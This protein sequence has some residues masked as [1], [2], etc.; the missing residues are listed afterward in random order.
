MKTKLQQSKNL[1]NGF[2]TRQLSSTNIHFFPLPKVSFVSA[3][4][5]V[6]TIILKRYHCYSRGT[7]GQSVL[8]VQNRGD[9]LTLNMSSTHW[10]SFVLV[11]RKERNNYESQ[12]ERQTCENHNLRNNNWEVVLARLKCCPVD[13]CG[14]LPQYKAK[15]HHENLLQ[16]NNANHFTTLSPGIPGFWHSCKYLL[17][18]MIKDTPLMALAHPVDIC[19]P[20]GQHV[21]SH[22]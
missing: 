12:K 6:L 5:V 22:H 17:T 18:Q 3:T 11:C 19:P 1:F 14:F 9:L 2:L 15:N 13:C 10:A 4:Q 21:L 16:F 8:R 20:A 7:A